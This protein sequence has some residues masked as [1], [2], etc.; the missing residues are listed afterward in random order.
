MV[1]NLAKSNSWQDMTSETNRLSKLRSPIRYHAAEKKL[2]VIEE[3]EI[4]SVRTDKIF[5]MVN[6][7]LM[8]LGR[9]HQVLPDFGICC[10]ELTGL[11]VASFRTCMRSFCSVYNAKMAADCSTYDILHMQFCVIANLT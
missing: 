1:L 9:K 8:T 3:S 6:Q 5:E 10:R 11:K 2:R 4:G 7:E